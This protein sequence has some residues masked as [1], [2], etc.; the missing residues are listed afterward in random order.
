MKEIF[1]A[2]ISRRRVLTGA[3]AAAGSTAVGLTATN[4]SA[5][6]APLAEGGATGCSPAF[7]PVSVPPSDPRYAELTVGNN[8]RWVASPESVRLVGSTDQVVAV[9]QEAVNAGKRLSVRG[10]GH[11][12]ADFVYNTD[13]KIV[14][15][16]S[17][18]DRVYFDSARKAFAVEGGALI[19]NLR[20]ALYKGWNVT[21][22]AGLCL[23]V[24]VGGHASGGGYGML[25][26]RFGLLSDHIEAVEMVVVDKNK[27]ARTVVASRSAADPNNDLW[28]ACTGGGGGNFG[29]IT[30]YWFR[31]A[32]A[33]GS[34]PATALPTPPK[35]V[36][37]SSVAVPW[38]SLDQT[39]FTAL[40]RNYG[41]WHEQNAAADS[42]YAAMCGEMLIPHRA[43]GS[44]SLVTE[45]DAGLSNAGQLLTDYLTAVTR[46]TGMAGPFASLK[47][48]WLDSVT[49]LGTGNPTLTTNPTL[50]SAIKSAFMR[51]SFTD[52]QIAALYGQLSRTDYANPNAVVQLA[53]YGGG[54]INTVAPDATATAHRSATFLAA[55]QNFWLNPAEDAAHLGFLRDEYGSV[56][57]G[58]GGYPIP[59]D[60]TDGCYI[61][62]PDPDIMDPTLNRSGVPWYQLYYKDNYPRLQRVK[63]RWDPNNIFRHSQ[64]ITAA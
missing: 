59:N 39:K 9:V 62:T 40:V 22:P 43:G 20:H 60:Q 15:D 4:G 13:T 34:S 29:V 61:N 8:Q 17:M 14:I 3:V 63:A 48:N 55:F 49:V 33:T 45:I 5:M 46:D 37:I 27:I 2:S 47:M 41:I 7:G 64:S 11:C 52:A 21:V 57:A 36:L 1:L 23:S 31:S 10:G 24:G 35:S 42:P 53:G 30:R 58:T 18:M 51:K 28:W 38:S 25:S 50:R 56:F 6:A 12:F 44:I 54:K 26:R 32:D 19:G 16:M